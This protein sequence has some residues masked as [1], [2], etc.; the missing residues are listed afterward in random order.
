[1]QDVIY[2]LDCCCCCCCCSV[3]VVVLNSYGYQCLSSEVRHEQKV[4]QGVNGKT[5]TVWITDKSHGRET[6]ECKPP[7]NQP[8]LIINSIGSGV[9]YRWNPYRQTS[10]HTVV[11]YLAS[12]NAFEGSC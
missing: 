10:R 2:R 12:G 5:K 1:M 7:Y 8:V 9:T 4:E 3:V 6:V 11:G